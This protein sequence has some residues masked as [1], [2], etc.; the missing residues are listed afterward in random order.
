ML[1]CVRF[2]DA[3]D[4]VWTAGLDPWFCHFLVIK[5]VVVRA[6]SYSDCIPEHEE[7]GVVVPGRW[8]TTQPNGTVTDLEMPGFALN[9]HA[10]D[11]TPPSTNPRADEGYGEWTFPEF[12][13]EFDGSHVLSD[14]L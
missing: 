8:G 11:R 9:P 1:S 5:D 4:D 14:A 13:E 12:E 7:G 3:S 10:L 2:I 6:F